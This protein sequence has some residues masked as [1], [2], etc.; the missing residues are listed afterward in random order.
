MAQQ[1]IV[2]IGNSSAKV[3]FFE[4]DTLIE[5]FRIGH[6]ALCSMFTRAASDSTIH[7]AIVS[8]VIPLEE[9]VEQ[10]IKALPYPCLR[11]SAQLRMPFTI[12]YKTPATLGP[13][14]LAAAAGAWVQ[15]PG[16]D[17]LVIDAGTAIT[18]DFVSAEGTYLGGNISPGIGM[19]FKALNLFTGKLPLINKEG[20]R[21][22]IGNTTETA[23]R[24]GVLQG[25][26]KEIESYIQEYTAKYPNLLVFLTGGSTKFLDNRVKSRTFAD[27]SLVI[28]GLNR[29]LTLNNEDI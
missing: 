26:D 28:K 11:M 10:A 27:S 2:D 25:V 18:Y 12:A 5:D 24:E 1:L 21:T 29:L 3:A 9:A 22:D 7:A 20:K 6:E 13:D 4:G 8:T 15:H 16:H 23:I 17:L 19:R 14:R